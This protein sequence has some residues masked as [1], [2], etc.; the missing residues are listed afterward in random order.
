MV[1]LFSTTIPLQT[2]AVSLN[3]WMPAPNYS[4]PIRGA[5]CVVN[6]GSIDCIGGNTTSGYTNNVFAASL[7]SNGQITGW[8]STAAY[9][10][11]GI[12]LTSC[13]VSSGFVYCIGGVH[14]GGT[15]VPDI[16]YASPSGNGQITGWSGTQPYPTPIGGESCV[17]YSSY[18]YCVGGT[19]DG[20]SL[21]NAVHFAH[22]SSSGGISGA[23]GSASYPSSI[24]LQSCVVNSAFIYCVAGLSG[25]GPTNSVYSASLSPN[26]GIGSWSSVV[27]YPVNTDGQS[28]VV[29]PGL[30]Y[31]VGNNNSQVFLGAFTPSGAVNGWSSTAAYPTSVTG[32]SCVVA[33]F[34]YCVGGYNNGQAQITN[35]VYFA[36]QTQDNTSTNLTCNPNPAVMN[37]PTTC[38]ATVTDNGGNGPPTTPT[39]LVSFTVGGVTGTFTPCNLAS[40]PV[41]G[42]ATCTTTF[43]ASSS[44]AASIQGSY[45][46]DLTHKVST[47][48]PLAVSVVRA[49]SITI[50]CVYAN[51]SVFINDSS[52]C[53]ATVIDSSSGTVSTPTGSV[54]FTVSGVSGDFTACTLVATSTAGT[55]GCTT[56]FTA[57]TAGTATINASYNGDSTFAT[58]AT[59]TPITITIIL[60]STAIAYTPNIP[61]FCTS[62]VAVNEGSTCYVEVHDTAPGT[63]ITPTGTIS[64][65]PSG[66]PG[67]FTPC[68]LAETSVGNAACTTTFTPSTT[69]V[70]T[71]IVSYPGDQNHTGSCTC[72][73]APTI[74]V[75][76][77]T[78]HPTMQCDIP[79]TFALMS[80]CTITISDTTAGTS[81]TPQGSVSIYGL[82]VTGSSVIFPSPTSCN[83]SPTGDQ[84]TATCTVN[85]SPSLWPETVSLVYVP[86]DS[87]HF[88]SSISVEVLPGCANPGLMG[89]VTIF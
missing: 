27:T 52:T 48:P 14:A 11:G 81:S 73:N 39:G 72:A 84:V 71:I 41:L 88:G 36:S 47:S 82:F 7:S 29:S 12:G 57:A 28:C 16:L 65:Q 2:D 34:V 9:P 5:S 37:Q 77:R 55:A 15:Y 22:L 83:L 32:T 53:T 78:T 74:E 21:T 51:G 46:G 42:T 62:P 87:V 1:V 17:V 31:C 20:T 80:T 68:R 23:W 85:L 3:P 63:V 38:T 58:S 40:G 79:L 49:S 4:I 6:S 26:G 24:K 13:V 69:G 89:W 30:V 59:T 66:V 67:T 25:G 19:T 44:G 50:S 56:A 76:K 43:T 61:V 45:G 54:I 86:S 64:F 60:R 35:A 33:A 70:A 8:S 75:I 10:A 18:V